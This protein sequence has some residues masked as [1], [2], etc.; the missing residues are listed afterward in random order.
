MR[1]DGEIMGVVVI[2]VVIVVG[3]VGLG[4]ESTSRS[5]R[6]LMRSRNSRKWPK[7]ARLERLVSTTMPCFVHKFVR[8]NWEI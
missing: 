1:G 2:M 7:R 3:V 8:S 5:A 6:V 4:K